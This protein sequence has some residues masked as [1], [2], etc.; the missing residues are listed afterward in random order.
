ME[1]ADQLHSG[2]GNSPQQPKIIEQG[3]AYL[4]KSFEKLDRIKKA[5]ILD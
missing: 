2:Y 3:N 5:T 1:F 4:D